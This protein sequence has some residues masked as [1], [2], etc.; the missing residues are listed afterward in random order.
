MSTAR[1]AAAFDLLGS[2][3]TGTTLLEASAGTGKTFTIAALVARYLAEG[4]ATVDELLIVT[5]GRLAT[6]ELRDRVRERLVS[7]R[8]A[9]LDAAGVVSSDD[10]LVRHLAADGPV[11]TAA[12]AAR[13]ATALAAFDSATV[14]TTHEFCQQVLRGLGSAGDLDADAT[15][16]ENLDDLVTEVVHDLYVRKWGRGDER[17]DFTLGEAVRLATVAV[18]DGQALLQPDDT[19]VRVRFAEAVR[20]EVDRR[21]RLRRVLGFDDL[22]TRLRDTLRDDDAGAAARSRLQG[23]YR[24]VLVDEFQDT[25]PVQWDILRLAFHGV[26][27]LVLIGDPKQAIYAFRGADVRAYLA[28]ADV[29]DHRATLP[30]N[31]RSD[32][33]LLQGLDR[34]FRGAALGDP[35]IVVVPVAPGLVGR[36]L[37]S[38]EAPV[39]LRVVARGGGD[40]LSADEARARVTADLVADIAATL[41]DA[42]LLTPREGGPARPVLPGDMA[43]I[44]RTNKQL[45][46]VHGALLKAGIPAVV[47]TASSVFATA[48]AREWL[49]LLEALEQPHRAARVRR[50]AVSPF[51]GWDAAALDGGDVDRLGLRVRHWVRV[52]AERGVAALH[53]SVAR[54]EH[55]PERLLALVNGERD[56]TDLRHVGEALHAAA[57]TDQLGLTALLEWLRHR[58]AEAERESSSERSRRLDSDAAAVQI[59]TVHASKGLEF[60]NVFVPFASDRWVPEPDEPLFHDDQG[61]RVRHI[62]G[63]GSPGLAAAQA[64]A[65][66][67]DF[68]EDLRLLYVAMT[69]AQA[70]VTAWWA[71]SGRN[72]ERSP[73]HRLLF[74][75]D[76]ADEVG[77]RFP[78]PRDSVALAT[79]AQ[80]AVEGCLSVTAAVA[81]AEVSVPAR[82]AAIPSLDAARFDRGLDLSWRRTSYTA[83][84]AAAHETPAIATEPEVAEK[85]DEPEVPVAATGA[86]ELLDVVSPMAALAG[87]A[88][89]GT[90]VHA[91]LEELDPV[92]QDL[93]DAVHER[94]VAES[95]RLDGVDAATVEAVTAGLLP[96]LRTP[97]GPVLDERSLAQ[98]APTDRLVELE[99]ELP[100][101]GG[102]EPNG[103]STLAEVGSLLRRRLPA[104]D[105]LAAYAAV[106]ADPV[107][108]DSVLKGYLTGSI[109]AVVRSGDRFVVIDYKTNRL[110]TPDAPLTAWDYRPEALRAAMIGAHYPLQALLYEVALHRFLRWR[111]PGYSPERHLG[112]ALYLFLRGMCGPAVRFGDGA[113]PGVFAW[114]PP[115]ELVTELSDLLAEGTR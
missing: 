104:D 114:R 99:F 84:T 61:R 44:V 81:A 41:R 69:R 27:T 78:V 111:V 14:V 21:K 7:T 87:G 37:A 68:G 25:D 15:L 26:A 72:T 70:R 92:A 107:L 40:P 42:P 74:S 96:A 51:V 79:I 109:D 8:D 60:P 53:E 65:L 18:N 108:G 56:L 103:T 6:Q 85:D 71:P 94:V 73:L 11:E 50:L 47:R 98:I 76:P 29:A 35:R 59:V 33:P 54:D 24:I 1:L 52:H 49:V 100:L 67:E 113:R 31:W 80:L 36:S 110:G 22:L 91:V 66:T 46:L 64:A 115:I 88:A 89:F 38:D 5:F 32:P 83:L 9:L 63:K 95:W 12:R 58:I 20:R 97:L 105:P 112:G 17:P 19:N 16:V 93:E 43:V 2:L 86:P 101:R 77:E 34:L 39:R 57:M 28:A 10:P 4:E 30:L 3:P 45:H 102:D 106:L 48:A 23:R 55:L 62:G 75:P 90:F 13:L 82:A